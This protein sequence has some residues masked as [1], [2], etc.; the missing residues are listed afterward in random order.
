MKLLDI[1]TKVGSSIVRNVVPGGGLIVDVVNELLP[2]DKKLSNS[3]TGSEISSAIGSLPA[4]QQAQ[5]LGREFDVQE[6]EIKESNETLREALRSDAA[7]PQSTR[8]Y[9]AKHSFHILALVTFTVVLLWEYGV[10]IENDSL[11]ETVQDGWPFVAAVIGPFVV[12]LMAYFGVLVKEQ[13][14]KLQAAGG[15]QTGLASIVSAFI[16][17]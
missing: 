16:K 3:A 15:V 12:L 10:G 6:T 11:V 8:P 5:I 17:K 2:D 4:E 9:I 1:L 14:Q 13:R 7:N